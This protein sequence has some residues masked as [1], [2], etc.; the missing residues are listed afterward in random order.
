MPQSPYFSG[1]LYTRMAED[2]HLGGMSGR[3]HDGYP[4]AVR[5]LADF[6]QT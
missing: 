1:P 2:P 6:R 5:K 3:T 4:R